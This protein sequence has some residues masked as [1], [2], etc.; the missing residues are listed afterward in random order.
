M[1]I[2]HVITR[3]SLGGSSE[4]TVLS[5][6][7]LA[8]AG[9]D[10]LLVTGPAGKEV[11]LVAA[12]ARR[13]CR[14]RVLPSLVREIAPVTDLRAVLDL[15]R[16]FRR[17]RPDLVHTH[18]SKAGFVGRLAARLAGVPVVVHT[19]HGHVFYAYYGAARTRLFIA[20]ERLAA[21]WTDRIV[22]LTERGAEEHLARGIGRPDQYVAIPSGVDVTSL[23]A[24]AP[25]RPAARARIGVETEAPLVVGVGRLVPVKG[26]DV[27]VAAVPELRAAFPSISVLLVG[28]GPERPALEARARALGVDEH[29]RI[30][31][32]PEDVAP[33]IAA[34]DVLAAP[35]RNEG[36]GRVLIEAMA[37]DVPVVGTRVGGIS[38]VLADGEFG[39]LVP[40]EAPGP[41]AAALVDLLHDAGRRAK[42][43]EAGRRR[44]EAFTVDVMV[45][46]IRALY[47]GLGRRLRMERRS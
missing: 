29:L 14:T 21:R 35:S 47:E 11:D 13:G 17:A 39:V 23:R 40:P 20:L 25:A 46:R 5:V 42:L 18:T 33:Y 27:L 22:V 4:N 30:V 37:L 19:P 41:L 36:M 31:G 9:H 38:S 12:A 44:A 6:I 45:S 43:A 15:V 7:G 3:L 16:M 8:A 26:F 1:K 32:P 24:R 34:A 2:V 28:D 10:C